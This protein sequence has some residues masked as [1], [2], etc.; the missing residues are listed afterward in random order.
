MRLLCQLLATAQSWGLGE[1]GDRAHMQRRQ[2]P[3]AHLKE[4]SSGNDLGRPLGGQERHPPPP[5]WQRRH[6]RHPQAGHHLRPPLAWPAEGW[7]PD[8]GLRLG[9]QDGQEGLEG[10]FSLAVPSKDHLPSQGALVHRDPCQLKAA[11]WPRRT[12][13]EVLVPGSPAADR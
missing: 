13:G 6:N 1:A 5:H 12:S 2:H 11:L 9:V 8:V 4:H 10:P 7:S 3:Q